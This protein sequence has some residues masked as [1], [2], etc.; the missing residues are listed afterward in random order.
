MKRWLISTLS[1]FALCL[2]A[3]FAQAAVVSGGVEYLWY[4]EGGELLWNETADSYS[5]YTGDHLYISADGGASYGEITEFYDLSR[6]NWETYGLTTRVLPLDNGGLRI[7]TLGAKPFQRDYSAQELARYLEKGRVTPVKVLATNGKITVAVRT[8]QD[9]ENGPGWGPETPWS[10]WVGK[11]V[12]SQLL[13]TE[14]GVTWKVGEHPEIWVGDPINGWWDG[15]K[16]Y[17]ERG[18]LCSS[19]GIHWTSTEKWNVPDP[20]LHFAT[21]LGPYH[22][23]VL[24]TNDPVNGCD[25]YLM[26]RTWGTRGVLLPH[27]GESIRAKGIVVESIRAWYG[28]DDTVFLAVYDKAQ[29]EK[30]M[31]C[32]SYPISSLDWCLE[33][34]A[35]DFRGP[36]NTTYGGDTSLATVSFD[37]YW[38]Y[39]N[40]GVK[41]IE[42]RILLRNDGTGYARLENLPFSHEFVLYPYTGKTFLVKDEWDNTLY[43]SADGLK[44]TSLADTALGYVGPEEKNPYADIQAYYD[45][46]WVGDRYITC[47]RV[48]EEDYAA[49]PV[50][51]GKWYDPT[52]TQVRFL[53]ESFT[54]IETHDFS[55]R[56]EAVGWLEGTYYARVSDS[57]GISYADF[58][59]EAGSTV[60]RSADGKSWEPMPEVYSL[61][62]SEYMVQ[63][64]GTRYQGEDLP[65][66]D[67]NKPLRGVAQLGD[68]RFSLREGEHYRGDGGMWVWKKSVLP[69]F[70]V[71][72]AAVACE[73][74]ELSEKIRKSYITPGTLTAE[75]DANG[76]IEVTVTDLYTTS[77]SVSATYTQKMLDE[78]VAWRSWTVIDPDAL[79]KQYKPGVGEVSLLDLPNGE[80]EL[81]HRTEEDRMRYDVYYRYY[82]S[83]PW[84]NSIELLPFSGKD[85]MVWDRAG[86]KLWLSSDAVTWWAAEAEWLENTQ[87]QIQMKW[88]GERYVARYY[89]CSEEKLGCRPIGR[90]YEV[91]FLNE[92]LE[93]VSAHKFESCLDAVGYLDGEY[94]VSAGHLYSSRD[95]ENWVER[96][97]IRQVRLSLSGVK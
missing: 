93:V 35:Q 60:Y 42:E 17:A 51:Q 30:L 7:E 2:C 64:S 15:E 91:L 20:T 9:W 65:T 46:R 19:D 72:D 59:R 70:L 11:R 75:Y 90:A 56:V 5:A 28:P 86:K 49:W 96:D 38:N 24:N 1:V 78:E 41:A 6:K 89:E 21:D 10:S 79:E 83:V 45:V 25:V 52:C 57:V 68:Y 47:C 50:R 87:G 44:W 67:P 54:L 66:N 77:M 84:S 14:D 8:V 81:L 62:E 29:G 71:G 31:S 37:E 23:E 82:E 27:M 85:F 3:P 88:T 36:E 18:E 4:T 69:C 61:D 73:L 53:D 80:T 34:L 58:D 92:D 32:I 26:N 33:N 43:A 95:G 40:H 39:R 74:W 55:R 63:D 12:K 97:D 48:M 76:D 22:F 94:Y 16:F 13:W